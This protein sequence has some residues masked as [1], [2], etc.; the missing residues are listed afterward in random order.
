MSYSL[1]L[2]RMPLNGGGY[3]IKGG[4]GLGFHLIP[5][6]SRQL[7]IKSLYSL[8]LF[9]KFA[10]AQLFAMWFECLQ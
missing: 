9:M 4:C 2:G 3:M 1:M 8:Y 7:L 5:N 10:K 6:S